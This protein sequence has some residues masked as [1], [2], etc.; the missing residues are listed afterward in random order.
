MAETVWWPTLV[1][2]V[3]II[4]GLFI[5]I[6]WSNSRKS[7]EDQIDDIPDSGF[8]PD[9]Y[10]NVEAFE[11]KDNNGWSDITNQG[12][13]R[14]YEVEP[15]T[16]EFTDTTVSGVCY[17]EPFQRS[18]AETTHVC[19][20]A[21]CVSMYTG[22]IFAEGEEETYLGPCQGNINGIQACPVQLA[23][24]LFGNVTNVGRRCISITSDETLRADT[25]CDIDQDYTFRIDR[26]QTVFARIS[27][28]EEQRCVTA[29]TDDSQTDRLTI[30][31]C[32][33]SLNQGYS[34]LLIPSRS[35]Q[36]VI[37]PQNIAYWKG[38]IND[39]PPS[40]DQIIATNP[41]V[42]ST[43]SQGY[44]VLNKRFTDR[45][46]SSTTRFVYYR[47]F[48]LYLDSPINENPANTSRVIPFQ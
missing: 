27:T 19:E 26:K 32:S 11:L 12:P 42:I 17:Y 24:W 22:E 41:Y 13:C 48:Q 43:D 29:P 23:R 15:L 47:G 30:G 44:A 38:D 39:P 46:P 33:N 16:G 1:A 14:I 10:V 20:Q 4:I 8:D 9:E 3:L 31:P 28:F 34:W 6:L 40:F 45:E 7:I 37:Y 21:E 2:F 25:L 5:V 35:Y 36:N 18:A